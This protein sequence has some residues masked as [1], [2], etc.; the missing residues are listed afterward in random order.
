MTRIIKKK[1]YNILNK[2]ID[3][4]SIIFKDLIIQTN[5][6]HLFQNLSDY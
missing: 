1:E 5:P 6:P 4:I 2:L 3:S